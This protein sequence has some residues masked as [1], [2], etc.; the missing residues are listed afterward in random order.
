MK[1]ISA[2]DDYKKV[3]VGVEYARGNEALFDAFQLYKDSYGKYYKYNKV[4]NITEIINADGNII[5]IVDE[6]NVCVVEYEYDT[7]VNFTRKVRV[8]CFASYFNQFVYKGYYYD[9]E[10]NSC[11]LNSRYYDPSIGRFISVDDVSYLDN[12]SL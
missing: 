2:E 1:A 7:W 8:D 4:G 11:Y 9:S 5:K 12:N 6:D 3:V 10:V